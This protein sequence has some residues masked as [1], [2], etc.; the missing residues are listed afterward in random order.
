MKS[1]SNPPVPDNSELIEFLRKDGYRNL[2]TLDNGTVI[3]TLDLLFTRS[4]CVG[5]NRQSWEARY[6]YEDRDLATRAAEA[7]VDDDL[8]PLQ[9]YVASRGMAK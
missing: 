2:K 7:Y 1:I 8:P 5:I 3:G 4:L 9:G 6:C